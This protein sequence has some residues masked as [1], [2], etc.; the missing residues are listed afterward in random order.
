ME[1]PFFCLVRGKGLDF[2]ELLDQ[3]KR[4]ERTN[5]RVKVDNENAC[6]GIK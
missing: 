2:W 3:L 4:L 5:V 6:H 1:G